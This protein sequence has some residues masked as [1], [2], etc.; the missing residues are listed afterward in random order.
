MA[1]YNFDKIPEYPTDFFEAFYE[2]KKGDDTKMK[3]WV[4]ACDKV[5]IDFPKGD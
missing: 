1:N 2:E 5:K 4:T 3:A